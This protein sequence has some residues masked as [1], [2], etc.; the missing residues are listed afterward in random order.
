MDDEGII[1][2]GAV[3]RIFAMLQIMLSLT[4]TGEGAR[5]PIVSIT[6]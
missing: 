6:N 2:E 5:G 3:D 1:L 4:D